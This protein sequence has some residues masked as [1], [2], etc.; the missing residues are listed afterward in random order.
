MSPDAK[1]VL[2]QIRDAK[3]RSQDVE[4]KSILID[5]ELGLH[6]RQLRDLLPGTYLKELAKL[7]YNPRVASRYMT[8]ATHWPPER[9]PGSDIL[10]QLPHDVQK[11]EW[12]CRLPLDRLEMLCQAMDLRTTGRPAVIAAVKRMLGLAEEDGTEAKPA[13]QPTLAAVRKKLDT[14]AVRLQTDLDQLS[15]P[16]KP[17]T[18]QDLE[19]IVAKLRGS[20]QPANDAAPSPAAVRADGLQEV[21][22][23]RATG[24]KEPAEQEEPPETGGAD[25][26]S[27]ATPEPTEEAEAEQ[28]E[29]TED[30]EGAPASEGQDEDVLEPDR[31]DSAT[32][33]GQ[34]GVRAREDGVQQPPPP[35]GTPSRGPRNLRP[36][37]S[38][39]S[40][41][42][43]NA[44]QRGIAVRLHGVGAPRPPPPFQPTKSLRG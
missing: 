26:V 27:A 32:A 10:L 21:E 33:K 43:R 25:D 35:R 1:N 5:R 16:E 22:A 7:G 28:P 44:F 38:A 9:T 12:L 39:G 36:S 4:G 20:L 18:L 2:A 31:P 30:E 41:P 37:P 14:F 6:F 42:G 34:G 3:R 17:Q 19:A 8:L 40:A 15:T 13:P 24:K 11:L 29:E 23:A